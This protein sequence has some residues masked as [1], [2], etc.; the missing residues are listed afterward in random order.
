MTELLPC[1]N[2]ESACACALCL[3]SRKMLGNFQC[4]HCGCL[5]TPMDTD[6]FGCQHS[7]GLTSIFLWWGTQQPSI[8]HGTQWIITES[9][10]DLNL[11]TTYWWSPKAW[12]A[13]M[14]EQLT[15]VTSYIRI[16]ESNHG[17]NELGSCSTPSGAG[18][19]VGGQCKTPTDAYWTQIK[20]QL[21][22]NRTYLLIFFHFKRLISKSNTYIA[23]SILYIGKFTAVIKRIFLL[24]LCPNFW[25]IP[26]FAPLEFIS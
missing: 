18:R 26:F 4:P 6:P 17:A 7:R 1:S 15:L 25:S 12:C 22:K 16:Y 8:S 24:S 5:L 13:K 9:F 14:S 20:T 11:L 3:F 19:F 23:R 10:G 2:A 21:L